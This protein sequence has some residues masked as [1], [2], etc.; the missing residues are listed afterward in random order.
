MALPLPKKISLEQLAHR[1]SQFEETFK[2]YTNE[3]KIKYCLNWSNQDLPIYFDH[4]MLTVEYID[5]SYVKKEDVDH[6]NSKITSLT[7]DKIDEPN[8]KE[9]LIDKVLS[10]NKSNT[11]YI[12]KAISKITKESPVNTVGKSFMNLETKDK[13][14]K[15][16]SK[17]KVVKTPKT[18]RLHNHE[19]CLNDYTYNVQVNS[20][21]NIILDDFFSKDY[22]TKLKTFHDNQLFKI[23][24]PFKQ[25]YVLKKDL[26]TFEKLYKITL[27]D[28]ESPECNLSNA[29]NSEF[30]HDLPDKFFNLNSP[31]YLE[32]IHIALQASH[33]IYLQKYGNSNHGVHRR[34]KAWLHENYPS[35]AKKDFDGE[36]IE[37]APLKRICT[38]ATA[39]ANKNRK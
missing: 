30:Y 26:I 4:E 1:W 7:I 25:L 27:Q 29:L 34:I 20:Q 22:G 8:K 18:I 36:F 35:Y 3:D 2:Q 15:K 31:Y 37:T 39:K 24:N 38:I 23:E 16:Q 33:A 21:T 11:A 32:E 28:H 6:N 12:E 17:Y 19:H 14:D 9:S 5:V 10:Y 13:L